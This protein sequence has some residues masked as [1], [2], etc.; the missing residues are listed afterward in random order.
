M[1][2]PTHLFNTLIQFTE[3]AI[4]HKINSSAKQLLYYTSQ[5]AELYSDLDPE[6]WWMT[7][8]S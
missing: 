8:V 1:N 3:N 4:G 2:I 6:G 5:R 7:Q